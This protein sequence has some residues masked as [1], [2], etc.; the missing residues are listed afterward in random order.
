MLLFFSS[1]ILQGNL[2]R[3]LLREGKL[4]ESQT[5]ACDFC[6]RKFVTKD[7]LRRHRI[8]LHTKDFPFLCD[9]CPFGATSK[10]QMDDHLQRHR[11]KDDKA[12]N[13][14]IFQIVSDR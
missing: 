14:I 11:F 1:Q 9:Q 4:P 3:K 6:G 8:V 2:K 13:G 10:A 5:H 7:R 12:E